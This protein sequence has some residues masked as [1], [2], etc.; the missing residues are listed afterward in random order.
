MVVAGRLTP[1]ESTI[2]SSIFVTLVLVQQRSIHSANNNRQWSAATSPDHAAR[3]AAG[4]ARY[5]ARRQ[6]RAAIRQKK[7]IDLWEELADG[8]GWSIFGRGSQTQLAQ[9]LGV[10]RSTICRDLKVIMARNRMVACPTC[11]RALSISRVEELERQ[12]KV[13]LTGV[14]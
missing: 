8:S 12:G 2:E 13:K 3:R 7:I 9:I 14:A 1:P 4:R 6:F 5:N 11:D 10:N